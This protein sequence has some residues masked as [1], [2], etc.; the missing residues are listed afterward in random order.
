MTIIALATSATAFQSAA[1]FVTRTA[2]LHSTMPSP[3]YAE[4]VSVRL[5]HEP[6]QEPATPA[7]EQK[8]I[9][10]KPAAAAKKSPAHQDGPFS[11]MVMFVKNILGDEELNKVRGKAIS[12]HSDVI[13]SFVSTSETVFGNAVLRSLFQLADKDGNGAIDED[14]LKTALQSLGFTWLQ[15]KQVSGIFKRADTDENGAIDLEEWVR[16]APKT[17]K[18]N[19]TKL[20]KK[21][22]GELGFLV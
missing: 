17:L 11:P 7:L 12:I 9:V 13:A 16:E 20:A 19:L 3:F 5:T 14:E 18:T 22:G 21:N 15:E 8:K 1:P 4:T 10:K 6:K 2:A